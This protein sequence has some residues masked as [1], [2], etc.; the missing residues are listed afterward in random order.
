M[1]CESESE[2]F[3]T[4]TTTFS[5]SSSITLPSEHFPYFPLQNGAHCAFAHTA[6][7]IRPPMVAKNSPNKTSYL[8]VLQFDQ[9]E[10]GFSTVV[11]G[12]GRDKTSFVIEDPQW[13]CE[14]FSCSPF[15][16]M[17]ADFA[18][19]YSGLHMNAIDCIV[20]TFFISY[21]N[22]PQYLV[23]APIVNTLS[24]SLLKNFVQ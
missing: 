13:H 1:Q 4:T 9:H 12:E 5:I 7:D 20:A 16:D 17:H 3:W 24:Y 8:S 6:N 18:M 21:K 22:K 19:R 15:W 2:I 23:L 14:L 10:V 11:D